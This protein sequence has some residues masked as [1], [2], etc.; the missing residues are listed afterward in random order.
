MQWLK[1]IWP[2][3]SQP[4][5]VAF[6][7][8]TTVYKEVYRSPDVN[9]KL[10]TLVGCVTG[11]AVWMLGVYSGTHLSFPPTEFPNILE[12]SK[13]VITPVFGPQ[14]FLMCLAG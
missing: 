13:A 8:L 14:T 10:S 11:G 3:D 7:D 5:T 9:G 1:E 2:G 6:A 12:P 4:G